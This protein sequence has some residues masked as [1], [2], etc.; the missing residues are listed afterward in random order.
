M[1]EDLGK[2]YDTLKANFP[3]YIGGTT[4]DEFVGKLSNRGEFTKWVNTVEDYLPGYF[5]GVNKQDVIN[6]FHPLESVLGK[7]AEVRDAK[8]AE[9]TQVLNNTPA[10]ALPIT[11]GSAS[12]QD[13]A[14]LDFFQANRAAAEARPRADAA[15]RERATLEAFNMVP[16]DFSQFSPSEVYEF[17]H[18][19]KRGTQVEHSE[20]LSAGLNRRLDPDGKMTIVTGARSA[21]QAVAARLT[22]TEIM[23]AKPGEIPGVSDERLLTLKQTVSDDDRIKQQQEFRE[24]SLYS[25]VMKS[26][27][28]SIPPEY[29]EAYKVLNEAVEKQKAG[30]LDQETYDQAKKAQAYLDTIPE[31]ADEHFR[32]VL[33]KTGELEQTLKGFGEKYPDVV[34]TDALNKQIQSNKDKEFNNRSKL[35]LNLL[36]VITSGGVLPGDLIANMA[37]GVAQAPGRLIGNVASSLESVTAPFDDFAAENMVR[38]SLDV[39]PDGSFRDA[40]VQARAISEKV[41]DFPYNGKTYQVGFNDEGKPTQVYDETGNRAQIPQDKRD[42]ILAESSKGLATTARRQYN[43]DATFN[44]IGDTSSDLLG[45]MALTAMTGGL[46]AGAWVSRIRELGSVMLQYSG[47]FAEEA[48]KNGAT[49]GQAA[50][51]G[52]GDSVLEGATEAI[53]PFA[54]KITGAARF[55]NL[56]DNLRRI[57]QAD[58]PAAVKKLAM[59]QFRGAI[60]GVP[61]EGLE[62]DIAELTHPILNR[63]YNNF[64]DLELDTEAPD[65]HQLLESF[66]LGAAVSVIPGLLGG[67][68]NA[69]QVGTNEFLA[70]SIRSAVSDIE[71]VNKVIGDFK[72]PNTRDFQAALQVTAAQV[73]PYLEQKNLSEAKKT[74]IAAMTFAA[75]YSKVRKARVQSTPY[76][77]DLERQQK[78]AEAALQAEINSIDPNDEI[79]AAISNAI[80]PEAASL[81]NNTPP[82]VESVMRRIADNG[83][84][85]TGKILDEFAELDAKDADMPLTVIQHLEGDKTVYTVVSDKAQ[86]ARQKIQELQQEETDIHQRLADMDAILGSLGIA[87]VTD[88]E[89]K[90]ID[91]SE[92]QLLAI[93]QTK[94]EEGNQDAQKAYDFLSQEI[95]N[96]AQRRKDIIKEKDYWVAK[97]V[98][99]DSRDSQIHDGKLSFT[100]KE[101][102]VAAAKEL[103]KR[104]GKNESNIPIR[105][106]NTHVRGTKILA[107]NG[108]VSFAAPPID[109]TVSASIHE[110]LD[111]LPATDEGGKRKLTRSDADSTVQFARELNHPEV[112]KLLETYDKEVKK[113]KG[114]AFSNLYNG[115]RFVADVLRTPLTEQEQSDLNTVIQSQINARNANQPKR[116][117]RRAKPVS[118]SG[119]ELFQELY[120]VLRTVPASVPAGEGGSERVFT[121]T[122]QEAREIQAVKA[123]AEANGMMMPPLAQRFPDQ[124]NQGR[125]ESTVYFDGATIVKAKSNKFYDSWTALIEAVQAQGEIFPETAYTVEGFTIEG[126]YFRIV[127][128][129]PTIQKDS[130]PTFEDIV[131]DMEAR[132]FKMVKG[133]PGDMPLFIKDDVSITDLHPENVYKLGDQLFYIDPI[134][135]SAEMPN[136]VGIG[137]QLRSFFPENIDEDDVYVEQY[138]ELAKE[139]KAT[140]PEAVTSLR[141]SLRGLVNSA[142]TLQESL[143]VFEQ[144][145]EQLGDKELIDAINAFNAGTLT[146]AELENKLYE[147]AYTKQYERAA[148]EKPIETGKP[149]EPVDPNADVP[150]APTTELDNVTREQQDSINTVV[151]N[152]AAN[153]ASRLGIPVSEYLKSIRTVIVD[154]IPKF[155]KRS[156]TAEEY[157][158]AIQT[159]N[160]AFREANA[161]GETAVEPMKVQYQEKDISEEQR[162]DLEEKDFS[163]WDYH[164]ADLLK[165]KYTSPKFQ[166][167]QFKAAL[168]EALKNLLNEIKQGKYTLQEVT[169]KQLDAEIAVAEANDDMQ[170]VR[171][172]QNLKTNPAAREQYL[173]YIRNN[174]QESLDAWVN[175]V[176]NP[177]NGYDNSFQYSIL[178]NVATRLYEPKY[179]LTDTG[180]VRMSHG[181]PVIEKWETLK[182]SPQTLKGFPPVFPGVVADIV[183]QIETISYGTVT[184]N[185]V[186]VLEA[187]QEGNQLEAQNNKEV[188]KSDEKGEWV[189]FKGKETNP[190]YLEDAKTLAALVSN[191]PWCLKSDGTAKSYLETGD[192]YIYLTK[193]EKGN[194]TVPRIGAAVN[195]DGSM[196]EIRG[197]ENGSAQELELDMLDT[198]EEFLKENVPEG[199]EWLRGIQAKKEAKKIIDRL[200]SGSLTK[201]DA[202]SIINLYN[203]YTEGISETLRKALKSADDTPESLTNQMIRLGLIESPDEVSYG[204]KHRQKTY[205]TDENGHHYSP[206]KYALGNLDVGDDVVDYSRLISVGH[207]IVH[208]DNIDLSSLKT[209]DRVNVMKG[210]HIKRLSLPALERV[211]TIAT[212]DATVSIPKINTAG[213][214]NIEKDGGLVAPNLHTVGSVNIVS[215]TI[216]AD[217]LATA[218]TVEITNSAVELPN[219]R[220]IRRL[221]VDSG[222]DNVLKTYLPKL[223]TSSSIEVGG[224]VIVDLPNLT[225]LNALNGLFMAGSPTVSI[226]RIWNIQYMTI[227]PKLTI[228]AKELRAAGAIS[229]HSNATFTAPETLEKIAELTV[230]PASKTILPN[231][232]TI[233]QVDLYAGSNSNSAVI[234]APKL[235]NVYFFSRDGRN[236]MGSKRDGDQKEIT[237]PRST[238]LEL[239]EPIGKKIQFQDKR[240]AI[241]KGEKSSTIL[242][243]RK[244][245]DVTTEIHEWLHEY[246]KVLTAEEIETILK[247]AGHKKWT[248]K[249]SEAFAKGGELYLYEGKSD[250]KNMKGIFDKFKEWLRDLFASDYFKDIQTL[251]PEMRK[252]YDTVMSSPVNVEAQAKLAED[253]AKAPTATGGVLEP[254]ITEQEYV[255]L[256][257]EF[258]PFVHDYTIV[259]DV[260]DTH[261]K[262]FNTLYQDE[263]YTRNA[264]DIKKTKAAMYSLVENVIFDLGPQAAPFLVKVLNSKTVP[265]EVKRLLTRSVIEGKYFAPEILNRDFK[266]MDKALATIASTMMNVGRQF[267]STSDFTTEDQKLMILNILGI[268]ETFNNIDKAIT[269]AEDSNIVPEEVQREME[270]K[271]VE[272]LTAEISALEKELKEVREEKKERNVRINKVK[273]EGRKILLVGRLQQ[274]YGDDYVKALKAKIDEVAKKCK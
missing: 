125:F 75:E 180:K 45:T 261:E 240:G 105:E 40:S 111:N 190:N 46:G 107:G 43:K 112:N 243:S 139:E 47:Q 36:S 153:L 106:D 163:G 268:G 82:Q 59:K 15:I 110:K 185:D 26:Q 266:P 6:R 1:N 120:D 179:A 58:D 87:E 18:P 117:S 148:T 121:A 65:A 253:A 181:V 267:D 198:A 49:I 258:Q 133:M 221:R 160:P 62:E 97:R 8:V 108:I 102:A 140:I 98:Y 239:G 35:G 143:T 116:V 241:L 93:L 158:K 211:D 152:I 41:A 147:A 34:L 177:H 22:P 220:E 171:A 248:D 56:K 53:F 130:P 37:E 214:I 19:G 173:N 115:L 94:I 218:D 89:G 162:L 188:F 57:I 131:A 30:E 103:Q 38:R 271:T 206:V 67:I 167:P 146:G 166:V 201:E 252:I 81:T 92:E 234:I 228:N 31:E 52:L 249:T 90:V 222:R 69:K 79:T 33:Q 237:F 231:T 247:W 88:A 144:I 142:A 250:N 76:E 151:G 155:K 132:G 129:Q 25:D 104:K 77:A 85:F 44:A 78:E 269:Q 197:I 72:I 20:L 186:N 124:Q 262:I 209:A 245:A 215:G 51:I 119:A 114:K 14:D 210:Y 64:F 135:Q 272:E 16:P 165:Q 170:Q 244:E 217:N 122:E 137:Q 3:E 161:P 13:L 169:D 156:V 194:P 74:Q 265:T 113:N 263:E 10:A 154:F 123:Y 4:G 138:P 63:A 54:A 254:V 273:A 184:I 235:K 255:K 168:K 174:Q 208:F 172:L 24:L 99:E 60:T 70:Q 149:L 219:L 227:T 17:T 236:I 27:V 200:K 256:F 83:E 9:Y 212:G 96:I 191:T 223:E 68:K 86:E 257:E 259:Q 195:S 205:R 226:P 11:N 229:V 109:S 233:G 175:Y 2:L 202:L 242:L 164:A 225:A 61:M 203:N 260:K 21:N 136:R 128:S 50:A 157:N 270:D 7:Q 12:R 196:R 134:I 145:A 193:D 39:Q 246:E 55:N 95:P 28:E 127:V 189:V 199:D 178:Y 141:N 187:I 84:A 32:T 232:H 126:G 176:T 23:N 101:K 192:L 159:L 66:A 100:D 73:R 264:I 29:F 274:E 71:G 91:P 183:D 216:F 5:D 150:T 251:T 230:R 42:A 48:I 80:R 224:N 213:N 204:W 207:L 238:L 182:R 118:P